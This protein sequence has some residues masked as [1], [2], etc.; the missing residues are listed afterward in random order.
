MR[1]YLHAGF[2]LFLAAL[3]IAWLTFGCASPRYLPTP[4]ESTP[5]DFWLEDLNARLCIEKGGTWIPPNTC[6][7]RK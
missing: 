7:R 1:Q 4:V 6:E 2:L 5:Y 3:L